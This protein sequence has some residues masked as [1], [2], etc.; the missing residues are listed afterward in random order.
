MG[1]HDI[2][3][4]PSKGYHIFLEKMLQTC[5]LAGSSCIKNLFT[6]IQCFFYISK[7]VITYMALDV[8]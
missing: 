3:N 2:G 5:N 1:H 8:F 7:G 4:P 6:G